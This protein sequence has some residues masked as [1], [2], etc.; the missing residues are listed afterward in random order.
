MGYIGVTATH[1]SRQVS[2]RSKF[3]FDGSHNDLT[4]LVVP[5]V[6][7]ALVSAGHLAVVQH[8]NQCLPLTTQKGQEHVN[9]CLLPTTRVAGAIVL[10]Q[11]MVH[12]RMGVYHCIQSKP[13]L[14]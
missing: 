6:V 7:P 2:G 8:V 1:I 14:L 12:L 4:N 11:V 13:S 10:P 9:Q 3:G 5:H